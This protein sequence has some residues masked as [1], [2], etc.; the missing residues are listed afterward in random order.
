[1]IFILLLTCVPYPMAIP[2]SKEGTRLG[3][4]RGQD[5][6]RR[7]CHGWWL[8]AGGGWWWWGQMWLVIIVGGDGG[9]WMVELVKAQWPSVFFFS[10][11]LEKLLWDCEALFCGGQRSD[12]I[13]HSLSFGVRQGN[14]P[15]ESCDSAHGKQH[16]ASQLSSVVGMTGGKANLQCTGTPGVVIAGV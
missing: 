1:M 4:A 2:F 5:A 6:P 13:L 3:A 14:A 9:C 15:V 8:V 16:G 10:Q 11:C 7:D 12:N